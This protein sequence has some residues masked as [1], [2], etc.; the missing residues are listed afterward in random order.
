MWL[1][2]HAW[3]EDNESENLPESSQVFFLPPTFPSTWHFANKD[4]LMWSETTFCM[5]HLKQ[6]IV[7]SQEIFGFQEDGRSPQQSLG[8]VGAWWG[9]YH[10]L[11]VILHSLG[12]DYS[13]LLHIFQLFVA[14]LRKGEIIFPN[15]LRALERCF[16]AWFQLVGLL[17]IW[18]K[19]FLAML[20]YK[21]FWCACPFWSA[22]DSPETL[23]RECTSEVS[24]SCSF[25]PVVPL[26]DLR[27]ANGWKTS[28]SVL[29][30][31]L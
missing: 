8:P 9:W 15:F 30:R 27:L 13:N 5:A 20:Q 11:I 1:I 19:S 7:T 17:Q 24:P 3:C 10:P 14:S 4:D 2:H 26:E 31:D 22:S 25:V 18:R 6:S 16:I 23:H 12:S 28:I 29:L 21:K